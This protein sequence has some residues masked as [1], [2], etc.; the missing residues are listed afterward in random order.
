MSHLKAALRDAAVDPL[1]HRGLMPVDDA[2]ALLDA[3]DTFEPG[4]PTD[5]DGRHVL[6]AD[7]LWAA[8]LSLEDAD[9]FVHHATRLT[10]RHHPRGRDNLAPLERYGAD[11]ILAWASTVAA[12]GVLV[13]VPWCLA[14]C[15]L[16]IEDPA[17][18]ALLWELGGFNDTAGIFAWQFV[19]PETLTAPALAA[20]AETLALRWIERHRATALTWLVTRALQP[21]DRALLL[22]RQ[23]GERDPAGIRAAAVEALGDDAPRLF[24]QLALPTGITAAAILATLDEGTRQVWPEFN[25]AADGRVEYFAMRM[26]AARDRVGDG[27]GVVFERLQGADPDSFRINRMAYG[28][29]LDPTD[30]FGEATWL[31]LK[32]SESPEELF[33]GGTIEGPAGAVTLDEAMFDT[34]D[35]RPGWRCELSYFAYRV[36]LVRAYVLAVGDA[37]WPD[38]AES[39]DALGLTDPEPII[40]TTAWHHVTGPFGRDGI[41]PQTW[42]VY[43]SEEPTFQSL[44][45]AL[46]TRDPARFEPG[47]P[48][49]DFQRHCHVHQPCKLPWESWRVSAG[50]REASGHLRA[51]LIEAAVTPDPRGLMTLDEARTLVAAHPTFDKGAGRRIGERWVQAADRHLAALLSLEDAAAFAAAMKATTFACAPRG[52]EDNLAPFDRYG[53]GLAAW[54]RA[55]ATDGVLHNTP[56]LLRANLLACPNPDVLDLLIHLDAF[57]PTPETDPAA[58][59]I[60]LRQLRDAWIAAHPAVAISHLLDAADADPLALAVLHRE[61]LLHTDRAMDATVTAHHG[62][63]DAARTRW[64]ELDL[65]TALTPAH[66]LA[67]LD[68]RADTPAEDM[69]AWPRFEHGAYPSIADYHGLRL[70]AVRAATGDAWGVLL[71]RATGYGFHQGGVACYAYGPHA[72]NGRVGDAARKVIV[73]ATDTAA[74]LGDTSVPLLDDPAAALMTERPDYWGEREGAINDRAVRSALAALPEAFFPPP[75]TV[76]APLGL[77]EDARIVAVTTNFEHACGPTPP[78]WTDERSPWHAL[79]STSIAFQ[80]LAAALVSRDQEQFDAGVSNTAWAT[81]AKFAT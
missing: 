16:A 44:A 68:D 30:P 42:E 26:I 56:P 43:P 63:P 7:R 55:V 73:R 74:I 27:W 15:L 6:L 45:E 78:A 71:E 14:P 28:S 70:I 57:A 21:D 32:I 80:S 72:P 76:I 52:R 60:A 20:A 41:P 77:G 24:A 64:A 47:E 33:H 25:Y 61:I 2:I 66:I 1:D 79:P 51:A 40:T 8:L 4:E 38:L 75:E 36:L 50:E 69:D 34:W 9:A 35:L 37:I 65:P 62:D 17:A 22:V 67:V 18:L 81:H 29:A 48:N 58:A 54:F 31:D 3:H 5:V 19:P 13:N 39:L 53:D 23:L 10:W 11:A 46:V 59:A 49:T 12:D